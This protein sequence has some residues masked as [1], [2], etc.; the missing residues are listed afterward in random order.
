MPK[1]RS[2]RKDGGERSSKRKQGSAGTNQRWFHGG[3]PGLRPGAT[4]VSAEALGV[5]YRYAVSNA[6]YAPDWVY[7]TAEEGV[8]RAYASRYVDSRGISTPGDVYE[9]RPDGRLRPDPDYPAFQRS[10]RKCK[11]V[12]PHGCV[13]EK[14]HELSVMAA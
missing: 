3:T 1:S 2:K 8:A 10:F 4:L 14:P 9:V 13:S 7:V 11:R 12:E 5:H 6:E